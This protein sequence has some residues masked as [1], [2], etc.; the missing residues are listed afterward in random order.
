MINPEDWSGYL[1]RATEYRILGENEK[2]C[3]D[4]KRACELGV[5]D[6]LNMAKKDGVCQ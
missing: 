5:C 3:S 6:L 4:L 1:N 2:A